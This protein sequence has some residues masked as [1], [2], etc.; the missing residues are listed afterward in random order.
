MDEI[1]K[2]LKECQPNPL[3]AEQEREDREHRRNIA[4]CSVA[5]VLMFYFY[6]SIHY[7][8]SVASRPFWWALRLADDVFTELLSTFF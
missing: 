2:K 6:T 3:L 4:R 7:P 8:E 1:H 5:A